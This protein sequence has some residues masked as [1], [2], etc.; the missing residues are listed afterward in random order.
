MGE[1]LSD[2]YDEP[3]DMVE[4]ELQDELEDDDDVIDVEDAS[5]EGEDDEEEEVEQ[6]ET[7]NRDVERVKEKVEA[8]KPPQMIGLQLFKDSDQTT[9]SSKRSKKRISQMVEVMEL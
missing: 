5:K 8:K 2:I 3:I 9:T 4:S 6:T 1:G 7:E